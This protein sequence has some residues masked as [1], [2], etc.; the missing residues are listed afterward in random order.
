MVG[1]PQTSITR[2]G[3]NPD[4]RIFSRTRT[5]SHIKEIASFNLHVVEYSHECAIW[6]KTLRSWR[7]IDDFWPRHRE[8]VPELKQ[9]ERLIIFPAHYGLA[10]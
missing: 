3:S 10:V 1:A 8:S 2:L 7:K 5:I 6:E 4:P 9:R